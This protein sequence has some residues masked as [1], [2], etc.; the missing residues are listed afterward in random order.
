VKPTGSMKGIFAVQGRV[1]NPR[2][3]GELRQIEGN[4][5]IPATGITLEN[6][7]LSVMVQGEGEGMRLIL[8]T[9]SGPGKIRVVGDIS[10][11]GQDGWQLEATATGKEFEVVHLPD[12]EIL[13]DPDLRFALRAGVMQVNGKVLVPRASVTFK[14]AAGLVTASRD[15]IVVDGDEGEKKD[16]PLLGT[17]IVELGPDVHVDAFGLKGRLLGSVTVSDAPGLSMTGK[18]GLTLHDGI[19]VVRDRALDISRGRFSFLG[20][21]LD[22]PGIDVLAQKKTKNKTVGVLASGTVNDMDLKLFSDPPMAEDAILTELLA[23]RSYSGTSHQVSNTVGAVATGLGLTR[24]GAFVEDILARLENQ[25]ALD[26]IYV[27]SGEKSSDISV[28]IGKELSKDLYISYGYDPFTSAGIFK[29]R[30]DLWKGFSV[31][32]EV[33]ADKTGADLLWSIEK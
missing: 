1:G 15:V 14:E 11:D 2:L 5:F 19:F 3:S 8:D 13:L 23:G 31:E 22:N 20:G 28:M 7:F 18:G 24:S 6:L 16:W 25:F 29:A 12:Y 30:Y 27:E 4:V 21:S 10:H 17:V 33:G 26:D 32:T 9:A